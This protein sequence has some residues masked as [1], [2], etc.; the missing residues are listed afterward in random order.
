[1]FK[2][3][4]I[5]DMLNIVMTAVI[6]NII[7]FFFGSTGFENV[8]IS[9]PFIV[10]LYKYGIK[11][12][13]F[14]LILAFISAYFIVGLEVLIIQ[15]AMIIAISS[16]SVYCMKKRMPIGKIV[17]FAA[18]SSFVVIV[19]SLLAFYLITKENPFEVMNNAIF[20][21]IDKIE[22]VISNDINFTPEM[23]KEYIV[24]F[25]EMVNE[26]FRI[27]PAI[28]LIYSLVISF[29][30]LMIS[31]FIMK[32]TGIKLLYGTKLNRLTLN[33]NFRYLFFAFIVFFLISL[34]PGSGIGIIAENLWAV[35]NA[36]LF[37]NGLSYID[38]FLEMKVGKIA[39]VLLWIIILVIFRLY[40]F[41]IFFG[42]MDLFTN[43][44]YEIRKGKVNNG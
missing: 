31:I 29:T 41:I 26:L 18:T 6:A 25:K 14:S 23:V 13:V 19:L 37:F 8:I 39:R 4:K 20:F 2:K 36:L 33:K 32:K 21:S 40:K 16:V 27:L 28:F 42:F 22:S 44:R 7:L 12:Y 10:V 1:M 24:Y 38:Y 15:L 35:A 34:I 9:A 11:E 43:I 3:Q 17:G 5:E 30:N